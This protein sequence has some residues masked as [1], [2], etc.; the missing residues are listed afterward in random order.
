MI[1]RAHGIRT[2]GDLG[3]DC[4]GRMR[5]RHAA[6]GVDG[7]AIFAA[8]FGHAAFRMSKLSCTGRSPGPV[9]PGAGEI[10]RRNP[11]RSAPGWRSAAEGPL[12][13]WAPASRPS[14]RASGGS[15]RADARA[16]GQPAR[17]G[18]GDGIQRA[19]CRARICARG[20]DATN[21]SA[22]SPVAAAAALATAIPVARLFIGDA[23]D[24]QVIPPSTPSAISAPLFPVL[25][26][27]RP[28]RRRLQ[29]HFA[30]AF[31]AAGDRL[32]RLPIELR[33]R[34]RSAPASACWP[35]SRPIWSGAETRSRSAR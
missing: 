28:A 35:G 24:F 25:G 9:C 34:D 11:R 4:R 30:R 19:D 18:A 7:A 29:P 1:A 22:A 17:C 8:R 16:A 20:A 3:L 2:P 33:A 31:I 5:L 21:S 13:R 15:A 12:S 32:A 26:P 14:P 27:S 23:P 6:C 10:H